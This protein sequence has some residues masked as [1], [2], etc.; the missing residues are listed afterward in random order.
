ME[1]PVLK[2]KNNAEIRQAQLE[3]DCIGFTLKAKEKEQKPSS[4]AVKQTSMAVRRL[5]QLWDRL[6]VHDGTLWRLYDD[7][8]SKKKWLRLVLPQSLCDEVLQQVHAGAIS[9]HFDEKKMLNQVKERFY[10]PGMSDDVKN[11]CHTCATC[12]TQKSPAPKARVPIQKARL[13]IDIAYGTRKTTSSPEPV[14]TYAAQLKKSL[15][16][17]CS[18]VRDQLQTAHKRQKEIYNRKVQGNPY[19]KKRFGVATQPG[20]PSRSIQETTSSMNRAI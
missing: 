13:P 7:N 6:K 20:S 14:T 2:E 10:W 1:T 15:T 3:D 8:A 12:A 5:I 18:D 16:A 17:A 19:Q 11:W 4:N 9:G